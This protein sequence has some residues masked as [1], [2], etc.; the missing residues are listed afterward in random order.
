MRIE[1]YSILK[2][3]SKLSLSKDADTEAILLTE[4]RFN[5]STGEALDDN[6]SEVELDMYKSEKSHL[7]GEKA[8]LDNKITELGKIIADIEAL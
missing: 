8:V 1:N 5:P 2:S 7:E 4:K 3:A 6:I